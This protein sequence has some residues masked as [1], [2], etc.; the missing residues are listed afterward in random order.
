[1]INQHRPSPP[2][3]LPQRSLAKS[4]SPSG[5][6][7]E[8]RSRRRFLFAS[9]ALSSRLFAQTPASSSTDSRDLIP[10]AADAAI[11]LGLEWLASRQ[12]ADGCFG[13]PNEPNRY[14][15]N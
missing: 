14:R 1:M 2:A 6:R 7:G 3:P 12:A 8:A 5:E 4:S 13:P 10:A 9:A 15:N 11:N